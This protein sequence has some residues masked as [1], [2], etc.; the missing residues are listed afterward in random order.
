MTDRL[1]DQG[2]ESTRRAPSN[3]RLPMPTFPRRTFLKGVAASVGAA[4]VLG[5]CDAPDETVASPIDHDAPQRS[6]RPPSPA[7]SGIQQFLSRHEYVT[8]EAVAEQILPGDGGVGATELGVATFVDRKLASYDAFAQPT[9]R[10]GPFM[11]TFAGSRP[12]E[13]PDVIFVPEQEAE[14]Y[15]FQSRLPPQDIYRRGIAALDSYTQEEHGG[16]FVDLDDDDRESVLEQVENGDLDAFTDPT[17]SLFFQVIY[18][19]TMQ[20]AFSDPLYGGNRNKLGWMMIGYPGAWRGYQPSQM[21]TEGF[22]FAE[23][24][25]LADAPHFH[26]GEPVDDD[27]LLPVQGSDRRRRR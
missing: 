16:R 26:P 10:S 22:R 23:P 5:A 14:R 25:S 17:S 27:V 21:R 4:T 9:Y 19:D 7:P 18:D 13:R 8:V 2:D 24:V 15:G 6:P 1:P 11:E 12:P 3:Q 20:G